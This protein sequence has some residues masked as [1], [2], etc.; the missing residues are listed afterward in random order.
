MNGIYELVLTENQDIKE[1]ILTF[2][3]A[4]NLRNVYVSGA[5]GSVKDCVFTA[6]LADS[7]ADKLVVSETMLA[8]PAELVAFVGEIYLTDG[9]TDFV[10]ASAKQSDSEYFVHLHGQ[11]AIAGGACYGGGF[12]S[13]KVFKRVK[14][15][16]FAL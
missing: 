15:Y 8:Q 16:L 4:H 1:G 13:G 12:K 7:T 11:A 10:P 14:V 3:K 2:I 9:V 5:I 6:P